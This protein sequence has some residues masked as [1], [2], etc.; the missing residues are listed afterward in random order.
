[1]QR[2][3][4]PE[5]FDGFLGRLDHALGNQCLGP[6]IVGRRHLILELL[7][8]LGQI[9]TLG[10]V[11]EQCANYG[12]ADTCTPVSDMIP[13]EQTTFFVGQ[14]LGTDLELL[15]C[16]DRSTMLLTTIDGVLINQ[17][18]HDI[19]RLHGDLLDPPLEHIIG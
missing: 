18:Q 4:N 9:N 2:V 8:R 6:L 17:L 5:F 10:Y 1:M 7:D 15:E 13:T 19:N 11:G 16:I 14:V 12:I 3:G